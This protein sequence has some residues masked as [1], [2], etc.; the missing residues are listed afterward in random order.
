MPLRSIN[1]HTPYFKLYNTLPDISDLKVFGC[2][3]FISTNIVHRTKF[4]QRAIPGVFIGYPVNTKGYKVLDL[5]T[6]KIVISRDAVFHEKH[7]PYHFQPTNDSFS[8]DIYLPA[9]TSFRTDSYDNFFDSLDIHANDFISQPP[10]SFDNIV[11]NSPG[12]STSD[13]DS[14]LID[15]SELDVSMPIRQST[16]ISKK[17]SYLNDFVCNTFVQ[18]DS[19]P[20]W[21]NLVQYDSL[22]RLQKCLITKIC[23]IHE[24]SSYV[25]ASVH[26]LWVEAMSKEISAL[27][28]NNTWELVDLPKGKKAIGSKWVFKVKLKSDGSLERCKARLV[29]KGFN[30][31]YGIDYE[32]TFSPVVKMSTIRCLIDVAASK[33]W[34]LYQLYVNNAFLHGDLVEEVFMKVPEGVPNP[35]NKSKND[36]SLFIRHTGSLICLAAVYVDDI[37]LTGTDSQGITHLKQHLNSEFGIKDLGVLNYFL[38]IEV[39]YL[40]SGIFLSQKKFTN[41]LLA[42]Y[43]FSVNTK[44]SILLPS[45]LKLSAW[46]GDLL[47]NPELYRSLVGKLN[48][49][50]HTRPDLAYAVQSLSQYMQQPRQ[51]HL[52]A[53]KHTLCYVNHTIGQGILLKADANITLQALSDSGWAACVDS[54]KSVTGYILLLGSSSVTWKSKKQTTISRSS[55]EAEYRAMTSATSEVTWLVRLLADFGVH[56]LKPVTLHCDN[57]PAIHIAKNPVFHEHTKHI[58]INCHF[59]R[60]KVLEGLIQLTYLPTTSQLADLLTK[61]LPAPQFQ[62]LLSKLGFHDLHSGHPNLRG[63]VGV[64]TSMPPQHE[65]VPLL[66]SSRTVL[67]HPFLPASNRLSIVI[68]VVIQIPFFALNLSSSLIREMEVSDSL[69]IKIH[70]SFR[71]GVHFAAPISSLSTNEVEL[72]VGAEAS[73]MG[74]NG[75]WITKSYLEMILEREGVPRV[76]TPPPLSSRPVTR[77]EGGLIVAPKPLCIPPN[78]VNPLNESMQPW[79]RSPTKSKMEPVLA[80]W[81]FISSDHPGTGGPVIDVCFFSLETE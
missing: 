74:I 75:P 67:S 6:K 39:S 59:T 24:P 46:D 42:E 31:R 23:D 78:L 81:R 35:D 64:T 1:N 14:T 56:N 25:K 13:E 11:E 53:L 55:S 3:C 68:S 60:D 51:P 4:D 21:C 52:A 73:R 7:F 47:P 72:T 62:L 63:G 41:E 44:A 17:P 30:Q 37:I 40:P 45:T 9:M 77:N 54:R 27:N 57:Q 15:L 5:N 71:A 36:Y 10:N 70:N 19:S 50:T 80:T 49:L 29:A 38:G 8:S 65:V 28:T 58:E 34:P 2:L 61:S 48:F 16:R 22:P 66:Q 69:I 26:P 20:H 33:R 12:S 79:T 76:N 43:P 32:E 18:A